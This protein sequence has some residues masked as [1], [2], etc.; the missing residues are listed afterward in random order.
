M[1]K[2]T[3][4]IAGAIAVAVLV[5]GALLWHPEAGSPVVPSAETPTPA[6]QDAVGLPQLI[7]EGQ[8]FPKSDI[9]INQY[10][11]RFGGAAVVDVD[12]KKIRED[13]VAKLQ[14]ELVGK[15]VTWDGY[16]RRVEDAPSGRVTLVLG[17]KAQQTGLDTA[18]IRFSGSWRDVLHTYR[19]GDRVRVVAIYDK[20]VSVFPSL[21]GI[22]IEEIP[23]DE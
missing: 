2:R 14:E 4:W 17:L 23:A 20:I 9:S 13:V 12:T 15:Q 1:N 8:E 19:Q 16:V 6:P 7:P 5:V 21:R 11:E 22:S 3:I 10:F 18:M